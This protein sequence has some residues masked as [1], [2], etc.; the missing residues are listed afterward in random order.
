MSPSNWDNM[1]T[2]KSMSYLSRKPFQN[3]QL[4]TFNFDDHYSSL[5]LLSLL[6]LLA[7]LNFSLVTWDIVVGLLE[8]FVD[9][10][11]FDIAPLH[12]P[13]TNIEIKCN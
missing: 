3:I 11:E 9:W 7:C 12:V 4:V 6:E 13:S 1:S 10:I 5:K 2:L 8:C